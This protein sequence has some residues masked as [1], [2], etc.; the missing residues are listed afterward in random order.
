[1]RPTVVEAQTRGRAFLGPSFL[2]LTLRLLHNNCSFLTPVNPIS[3]F[4]A[5]H[6][7]MADH[8]DDLHAEQTEGFKVGEKK[9]IDEYQKLGKS[10]LPGDR[11]LCYAAY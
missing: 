9:T 5:R 11:V 8:A 10:R 6:S 1:M 7:N 4:Q 3:N 2:Q